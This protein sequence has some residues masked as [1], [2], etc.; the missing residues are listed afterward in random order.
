MA[1]ETQLQ[2]SEVVV[3]RSQP[4]SLVGVSAVTENNHKSGDLQEA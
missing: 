1:S 2:V 3:D 4:Q